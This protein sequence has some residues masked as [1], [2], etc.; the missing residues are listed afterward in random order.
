MN[1][2]SYSKYSANVAHSETY[3][4]NS[5]TKNTKS[6]KSVEVA[7]SQSAVYERQGD[8]AKKVLSDTGYTVDMDKVHAMKAEQDDHMLKIFGDTVKDTLAKQIQSLKKFVAASSGYTSMTSFSASIQAEHLSYSQSGDGGNTSYSRSSI[9]I[10]LSIT[11]VRSRFSSDDEGLFRRYSPAEIQQA[12]NDVSD[13]GY[14][15]ADAV[16]S[17]LLDFAK[18]LSGGDQSKASL[19]MDAVKKGFK[20]AEELWGDDLPQLSKDTLDLT[21]K[22]FDQWAKE[23]GSSETSDAPQ[24]A[25]VADASVQVGSAEA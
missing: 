10:E 15:G 21:M 11:Q 7:A 12:K 8:D 18:A 23:V 24:A 3:T 9:T 17:R 19:L 25:P 6:S 20:M 22:K 1:I 2:E 4:Q 14:W 5:P 16:S 13:D